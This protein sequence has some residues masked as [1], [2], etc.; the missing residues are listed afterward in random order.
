MKKGPIIIVLVIIIVAIVAFLVFELTNVYTVQAPT[1]IQSQSQG[2]TT[3]TTQVG[4]TGQTSQTGQTNQTGQTSQVP[5]N[6]KTYTFVQS[7]LT[8]QA[9]ADFVEQTVSNGV[10]LIIPTTTPYFRTNLTHEAYIEIY[11]PTTTC[12]KNGDVYSSQATTT[13][14]GISYSRGVWSGV[15]AGNL[16]QGIDYTTSWNGLCQEITLYTHGTDGEGFYTGDQ[17]VIQTDDAEQKQDM[18]NIFNLADQIM[19]TV[20]LRGQAPF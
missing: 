11:A 4:Q 2:G 3:S 13:F 8:L 12:V 19:G 6:W 15:G 5:T 7:N 9:P 1:Q 20:T 18:A 17:A 14:N 16:Y 10:E